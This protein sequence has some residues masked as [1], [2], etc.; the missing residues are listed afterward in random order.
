MAGNSDLGNN[1]AIQAQINQLLVERTKMLDEQETVLSKQQKLYASIMGAF[2]SKEASKAA[3][4]IEKITKSQDSASKATDA[5]TN[6]QT[7]FTAAIKKSANEAEELNK[8]LEVAAKIGG[9]FGDALS[10]AASSTLGLVKSA[11][12]LMGTLFNLGQVIISIPFKTWDAFVEKSMN[13]PFNPAFRQA[14]ED[15][16]KTFGDLSSGSGKQVVDMYKTLRSEQNIMAKESGLSMKRIF[17]YGVEGKAAMLKFMNEIGAS[18]GSQLGPV[19]QQIGKDLGRVTY[20]IKAMG[21]ANEEAGAAMKF[22]YNSG[23]NAGK[24]MQEMAGTAAMMAKQTGFN[25]KTLSK[26]MVETTSAFP[27][28]AKGGVKAMAEVAHYTHNL[29]IEVKDLQAVFD[30]FDSFEGAAESASQLSQAFG[31]NIDAMKMVKEQSPTKRLEELRNAFKAAGKDINNMTSAERKLAEATTG[32]TGASFE[33][34]M[35]EGNKK[36]ALTESEKASNAASLAAKNQ[37]A[38]LKQLAKSIERIV[39]PQAEKFQGFFDA[40]T[41]GFSTGMFYSENMR[42]MMANLQQSF[43]QVYLFGRQFAMLLFEKFPGMSKLAEGFVKIFDP[44]KFRKFFDETL[45]HFRKFFESLDKDPKA[46]FNTLFDSLSKSIGSFFTEGGTDSALSLIKKGAEKILVAI[47]SILGSITDKVLLSATEG[48]KNLAKFIKDPSSF[49]DGSGAVSGIAKFFA[50]MIQAIHDNWPGIKKALIGE[51]QGGDLSGL[52]GLLGAVWERVRGPLGAIGNG[53]AIFFVAKFALGLTLSLASSGIAAGIKHLF[54]HAMGTTKSQLAAA[55]KVA[56]AEEA[57]AAAARARTAASGVSKSAWSAAEEA[58]EKSKAGFRSK[59]YKAAELEAKTASRAVGSAMSVEREAQLALE[60][61]KTEQTAAKLGTK[62]GKASEVISEK[63]AAIATKVLGEKAAMAATKAIPFVGWALAIADASTDIAEKMNMFEGDLQKNYGKLEGT[64][65]AGSAG[66]LS[67]VTLGLLPDNWYKAFGESAAG[68][69]KAAREFAKKIGMEN[70]FDT[71]LKNIEGTLDIFR[72]LGDI[73]SGIFHGDT[74]KI[75][76]GIGEMF[77]GIIRAVWSFPALIG[78]A[79]L[80]LAPMLLKGFLKLFEWVVDRLIDGFD[81]LQKIKDWVGESFEKLVAWWEGPTD[82]KQSF[83]DAFSYIFDSPINAVKES[84]NTFGTW[85]MGWSDKFGLKWDIVKA[86]AKGLIGGSK[87]AVIDAEKALADYEKRREAGQG[88]PKAPA[89]PAAGK[90]VDLLGAAKSMGSFLMEHGGNKLAKLAE[91]AFNKMPLTP[92]QEFMNSFAKAQQTVS[93]IEDL[94][95]LQ[96]K[97]VTAKK[98]FALLKPEQLKK[99]LEAL[100]PKFT[101][102]MKVVG[103][104][105]IDLGKTDVSQNWSTAQANLDMIK[106]LVTGMATITETTG[107]LSKKDINTVQPLIKA[108][109]DIKGG[110]LEITHNIPGVQLNVTVHLDAEKVAKGVSTINISKDNTKG[111]EKYFGTSGTPDKSVGA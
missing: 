109:S 41:K 40:F 89:A 108:L 35:G 64:I 93:Q 49:I 1:A 60:V 50:P 56:K 66:M 76:K 61:A 48:M 65:G 69:T 46:A 100:M 103:D 53:L 97:L 51:Y 44:A 36:K 22:F 94:K 45:G 101:G 16:R 32:L 19:M 14:L 57:A 33:A 79:L 107:K 38:A 37:T 82:W 24:M 21:L 4:D 7:D 80:D 78:S 25:I 18:L 83:S 58:A 9:M 8:K 63:S 2:S 84:F 98:S 10:G 96:D 3:S 42:K 86:K 104:F 6:S 23:Q 88:G 87:E 73:I 20:G 27:Q 17:G 70:I 15:T 55:E 90:D 95:T 91:E 77:D 68:F 30:K 12:N 72:G 52:G 81:F 59:A 47:S 43:R 5:A 110:K 28:F 13:M 67:V 11:G 71:F 34:A 106:N 105:G 75:V 62:L 85:V 102:A 29:G 39:P 99:D 92:E 31:V 111:G 26:A 54:N 74:D